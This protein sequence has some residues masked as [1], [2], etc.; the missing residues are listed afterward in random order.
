[1]MKMG[2]NAAFSFRFSFVTEGLGGNAPFFKVFL[3]IFSVFERLCTVF[4]TLFGP[5]FRL[6]LGRFLGGYA[7]FY[8][9][10]INK[11]SSKFFLSPITSTAIL[12]FLS[13]YIPLSCKG[14]TTSNSFREALTT[15][16]G[17]PP[18]CMM[19]FSGIGLKLFPVRIIFSPVRIEVG[20]KSFRTNDSNL[21]ESIEVARKLFIRT[22]ILHRLTFKLS[23]TI[24][25]REVFEILL[26][27]AL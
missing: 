19:L 4:L 3:T 10:F 5:I 24:T 26:I 13:G 14:T 18:I 25:V 22:S 21:K 6:G 8:P 9:S 16:A 12:T 17:I 2:G 11:V 20:L 15:L 7:P 1:M 27:F 23:G